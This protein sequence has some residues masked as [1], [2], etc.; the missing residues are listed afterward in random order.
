MKKKEFMQ[1]FILGQTFDANESLAK[2]TYSRIKAATEMWNA[3][4]EEGKSKREK[5]ICTFNRRKNEKI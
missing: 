2:M 4:E 3:I 5:A 1:K